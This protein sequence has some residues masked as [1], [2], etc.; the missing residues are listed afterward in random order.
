MLSAETYSYSNPN[1]TGNS[2][3]MDTALVDEDEI[4]CYQVEIGCYQVEI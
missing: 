2:T 4:G 1:S 3:K